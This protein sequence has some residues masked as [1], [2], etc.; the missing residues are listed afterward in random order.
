[1]GEAAGEGATARELTACGPA[2]WGTPNARI[3]SAAATNTLR[4]LIEFFRV[5]FLV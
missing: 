1:M 3:V 5:V 2:A 4:R